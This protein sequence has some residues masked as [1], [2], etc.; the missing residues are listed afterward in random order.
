MTNFFQIGYAAFKNGDPCIPCQNVELQD[1]M[2]SAQSWSDED[3][4]AR[5]DAMEQFAAGVRKASAEWE[6]EFFANA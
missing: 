4:A 2:S 3:H 1:A 5:M 6:E